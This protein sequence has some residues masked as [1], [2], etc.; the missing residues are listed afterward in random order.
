MGCQASKCVQCGA[1]KKA[2]QL[3][4]GKCSNCRAKK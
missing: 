4:D 3:I 1:P 2:C